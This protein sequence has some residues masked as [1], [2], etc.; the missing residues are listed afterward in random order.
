MEFADI[1]ITDYCKI[2]TC[3]ANSSDI[4]AARFEVAKK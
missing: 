3:T 1:L 4:E 2:N